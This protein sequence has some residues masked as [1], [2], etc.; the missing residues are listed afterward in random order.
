MEQI[1]VYGDKR[2]LA[3]CAFCGGKTETRDHCPSR[4]F[5]DEPYPQNLPV[6]FACLD[7]NSSFSE[8]EEYFACL[9]SCVIAGTT[10]PDAMPRGKTNRIL[11]SKPALRARIE[12]SRSVIDGI[13]HFNPEHERVRSVLTKLAQGHALY[14][15]HESC[16]YP[17]NSVVYLP[18]ARMS[19]AQRHDF[20]NPEH[21]GAWPEVG[22]RAMQR[23][24]IG[25]DVTLGGWLDVQDGLYRYHASHGG[26]IDVRIVIHEYLACHVHWE[27]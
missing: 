4:V 1:Q 24:I 26:G 18:L 13:T 25:T 16:A 5:L 23:A 8:D 6:V 21:L 2:T 12:Q 9:V 10:A 22:S 14:E 17:P 15:L 3:F 20:E 27:H 7:C 11:K 19:E